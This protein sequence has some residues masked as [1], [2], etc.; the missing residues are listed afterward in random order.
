MIML[1][2]GSKTVLKIGY[3]CA[4]FCRDGH[5]GHR[6]LGRALHTLELNVL[7]FILEAN[8]FGGQ[9]WGITGKIIIMYGFLFFLLFGFYFL[10]ICPATVRMRR[11]SSRKMISVP[12]GS[13]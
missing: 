12:C 9:K 6:G 13:G 3:V 1:G 2:R 10:K 5:R 11:N 8:G 4:G 7:D